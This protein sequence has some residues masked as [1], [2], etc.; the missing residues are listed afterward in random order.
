[1]KRINTINRKTSQQ[2]FSTY[3]KWRENDTNVVMTARS[4]TNKQTA[5]CDENKTQPRKETKI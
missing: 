5:K 1:M 4:G 2:L 3:G